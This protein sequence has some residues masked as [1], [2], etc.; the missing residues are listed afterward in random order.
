VSLV[1]RDEVVPWGGLLCLKAIWNVRTRGVE[2]FHVNHQPTRNFGFADS[3]IDNSVGTKKYTFNWSFE[4]VGRESS[5]LSKVRDGS[6]E[7]HNLAYYVVSFAVDAVPH[8]SANEIPNLSGGMTYEK[9]LCQSLSTF[10]SLSDR[11]L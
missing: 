4:V 7:I 11:S 5:I 10:M 3:G 6:W 9:K 2:A 1:F 8:V